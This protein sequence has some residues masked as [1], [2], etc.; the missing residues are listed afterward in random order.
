MSSINNNDIALPGALIIEGHVQGLSNTRSLGELG[1]PVFVIDTNPCLAQFSK[2]CKRFFQCPS[3]SSDAFIAYL[4]ELAEKEELTG[5][6]ILASNDHIV[7]Q[8]SRNKSRLALYFRFLVPDPSD[9]ERIIDKSLL[10]QEAEKCC[11][12]I[13]KTYLLHDSYLPE[14]IEFPVLVKG[15]KGL[16]FYKATHRKAIQVNNRE[17]LLKTIDY[18]A[19]RMDGSDFMIQELINCNLLDHTVSFTCFAIKGV[20]KAYWIGEKLREHPIQYG[21]ATFAQSIVSE[22]VFHEA[23]SLIRQLAY[24]GICEIEFLKDKKDG[25]YKLI[26]INPRTWLWVGLAKACGIDYAKM[27]YWYCN[28]IPIQYPQKYKV[29]IKWI[30]WVTDGVFSLKAIF[31]GDL[32]LKSYFSSLRGPKIRA[33]WSRRDILPGIVFPFMSLYIAQKRK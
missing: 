32:S 8:L 23:T 25:M 14:E 9:L 21:T 30:N 4:I 19:Q 15:C 28:G 13:P 27:A 11:V 7:E 22:A 24:S 2:Y 17:E 20:I 10:M 31:T 12:H 16:S 6:L 5:W 33:I 26:E 1:I 18:L 29:G 3:F